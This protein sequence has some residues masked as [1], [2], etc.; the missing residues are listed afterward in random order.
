MTSGAALLFPILYFLD[1]GGWFAAVLPAVVF[2]ELGH[3]LAL[4]GC[5]ADILSIRLEISGLCMRTGP[6]CGKGKDVLC[7][8]AGPIGGFIWVAVAGLADGEWASKSFFSAMMLNAFNLLPA[9]PLDGGRI[10]SELTQN[11]TAVRLCT[12]LT[13]VILFFLAFRRRMWG[14]CFPSALLIKTA[15][16]P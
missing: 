13:G 9:M 7:A 15:V 5:G 6:I 1:D 14:L 11:D 12:M 3:I 4:K 10:L 2:H 16:I 8:A